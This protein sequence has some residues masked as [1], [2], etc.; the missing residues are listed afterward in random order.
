NADR[1]EEES[2]DKSNKESGEEAEEQERIKEGADKGIEEALE[3]EELSDEADKNKERKA[4]KP[5]EFTLTEYLDTSD[6]CDYQWE[7]EKHLLLLVAEFR[8]KLDNT[9]SLHMAPRDSIEFLILRRVAGAKDTD[10]YARI[11]TASLR[12]KNK[13]LG[14][15]G[16]GLW[17]VHSAYTEENRWTREQLVIV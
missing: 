15:G 1:P 14:W 12:R 13:D 6:P 9:L 10:Q 11:G 8:D 17:G 5:K 2:E 16:A 3:I 4:P 7:K